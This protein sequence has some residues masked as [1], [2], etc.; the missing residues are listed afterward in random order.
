MT[1]EPRR[2]W[3]RRFL[4][5]ARIE[6][7]QG[8]LSLTTIGFVAG[9]VCL[10]SGRTISLTELAAFT[11]GLG[12]H[13]AKRFQRHR[14]AEIALE[15][16]HEHA[17]LQLEQQGTADVKTLGAKIDELHGKVRDLATPEMKQRWRDATGRTG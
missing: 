16:A 7:E 2:H 3:F 6:D 17:M 5:W 12:A 10:L 14:T 9:V 11:V 13:H 1:T 8:V 15:G 4:S